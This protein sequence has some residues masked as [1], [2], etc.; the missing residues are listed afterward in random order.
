MVVTYLE[1]IRDKFIE[2]K[3]EINEKLNQSL[4][5]HKENTEFIKLLE[6][7]NDD[8][9]EAFTPRTIN[10]F[11]KRKIGEL[12]DEQKVLENTI[13][14]IKQRLQNVEKEIEEVNQIIK[15]AKEKLI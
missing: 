14:E 3:I 8:N 13:D 1:K 2:E 7:N 10:S 9:F 12:K 11:N 4:I 15:V 5:T 6:L